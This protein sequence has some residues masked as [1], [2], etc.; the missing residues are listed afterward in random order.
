MQMILILS[1]LHGISFI[2][3]IRFKLPFGRG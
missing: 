3:E 2:V 1:E